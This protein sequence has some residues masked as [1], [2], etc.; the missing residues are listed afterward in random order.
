M[1]QCW[2]VVAADIEMVVCDVFQII[3]LNNIAHPCEGR[4]N[5]WVTHFN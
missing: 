5:N 4:P 3:V 2:L 1:T